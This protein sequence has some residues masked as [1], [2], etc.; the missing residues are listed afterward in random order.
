M[1]SGGEDC[2][3]CASKWDKTRPA[4]AGSFAPN[5]FALFDMV[6]NVWQWLDD[7]W[8]EN[9]DGAPTNGEA[10]VQGGDCRSRVARGGSWRNLPENSRSASRS[11]TIVGGRDDNLGF[12]VARTLNTP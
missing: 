11:R 6:G 4:P 12:R 2:N 9:Y 3:G 7:C 10:W 5:R 8:H 1:G